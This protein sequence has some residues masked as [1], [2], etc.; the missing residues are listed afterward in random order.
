MTVNYKEMI[1]RN[2]ADMIAR[3]SAPKNEITQAVSSSAKAEPTPQP[4]PQPQPQPGSQSFLGRLWK[5]LFG[6]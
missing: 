4:E 6:G 1:D 5:R 2:I 3:H